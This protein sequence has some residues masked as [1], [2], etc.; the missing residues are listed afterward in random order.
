MVSKEGFTGNPSDCARVESVEDIIEETIRFNRLS[1]W[2]DMT[3]PRFSTGMVLSSV[4]TRTVASASSPLHD[5]GVEIPIPIIPIPVHHASTRVGRFAR[6]HRR[7]ARPHDHTS[8][9]A[10]GGNSTDQ[11]CTARRT[12]SYLQR[13]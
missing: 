11:G 12:A 2:S 6:Q 10:K 13:D 8:Q 3:L 4:T 7:Y 9:L 5:A 1:G